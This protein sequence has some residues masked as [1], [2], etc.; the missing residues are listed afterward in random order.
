[1]PFERVKNFLAAR[2][3][4]KAFNALSQ[5]NREIV[6]YSE[7]IHSFVHFE[8][9]INGLFSR[10]KQE[11]CYLTSAPDDPLLSRPLPGMQVFYI[12]E[13]LVRTTVFRTLKAG[14]LVM[15]MPDLENFHIKRSQIFQVHYLYLFHAMV[16]THSNYRKAAFDNFDTIFCTGSFQID[17]IRATETEYGLKKKNLYSDGYRRLEAII[18][19]VQ[20]HRS[21]TQD[22]IDN[23]KKTVI[24]APSW[25]DNAIL[26]RCGEEIVEVLLEAG[27]NT[28]VRPHPMTTKH[29]PQLIEA[30]NTRFSENENF[31]LQID[32]RDNKTLYESHVMISDWSGVAMEYAFACE[33]PVVFIDLPKKCNNPEA[34]RIPHTPIEV[35][36]RNKVGRV[37]SPDSLGALPAVIED[38]YKDTSKFTHQI[39]A[40][41]EESV[42]NLG[43]SIDGAV[44]EIMRI[45]STLKS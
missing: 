24:V 19:D 2:R 11:V 41:R 40:A 45:A 8:E 36:I 32:V 27:Y 18:A 9:I 37:V 4:Q 21:L 38:I 42:F 1:M 39:R 25:G 10:Y 29:R 3:G 14:L 6:F 34:D 43:G 20:R 33:R 31:S 22:S 23:G 7:D 30:I 13:G 16:S 28:I 17:E 12:G 15:T 44:D 26:E 35:S 5:A